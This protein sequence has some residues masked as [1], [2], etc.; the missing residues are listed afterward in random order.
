VILLEDRW[1]ILNNNRTARQDP[2]LANYYALLAALDAG[3]EVDAPVYLRA[4][5]SLARKDSMVF[6]FVLVLRSR[7]MTTLLSVPEG[8]AICRL[9]EENGWTISPPKP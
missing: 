3:W 8:K 7:R 5:W 6:H 2:D 9:I 4:D 1:S